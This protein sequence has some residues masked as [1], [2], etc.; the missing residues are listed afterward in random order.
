MLNLIHTDVFTYILSPYLYY[1]ADLRNLKYLFDGID[2]TKC[3]SYIR[4]VQ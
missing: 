1:F 3:D 2:C 4:V